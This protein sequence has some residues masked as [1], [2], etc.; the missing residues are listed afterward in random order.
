MVLVAQLPHLGPSTQWEELWGTSR[1]RQGVWS[2]AAQGWGRGLELLS[3]TEM[4]RELGTG[5]CIGSWVL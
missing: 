3:L 5:A 2:G 1:G 4:L